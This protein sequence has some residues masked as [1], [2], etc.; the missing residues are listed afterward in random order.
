MAR[1]A[2]KHSF[3]SEA[4]VAHECAMSCGLHSNP[5]VTE[6]G[7]QGADHMARA[8]VTLIAF[9]TQTYLRV[10]VGRVGWDRVCCLQTNKARCRVV[11]IVRV[12]ANSMRKW[13]EGAAAKL[14]GRCFKSSHMNAGADI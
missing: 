8:K 7:C 14:L 9:K 1:N 4:L 12:F 11:L 10:R 3:C 13:N 6:R 2:G 5:C